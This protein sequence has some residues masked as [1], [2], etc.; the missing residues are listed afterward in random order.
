MFSLPSDFSSESLGIDE[1]KNE[2]KPKEDEE[3]EK[4]EEEDED[5]K[6]QEELEQELEEELKN[7]EEEEHNKKRSKDFEDEDEPQTKKIKFNL[8]E[9][10]DEEEEEE[11]EDSPRTKKRKA[12]EEDDRRR[13]KTQK[14]LSALT[15]TQNKRYEMYKRSKFSKSKMKSLISQFIPGVTLNES[16]TIVMCGISKL[17]VGDLVE[18]SKLIMRENNEQ[19][20]I[21]P[22]HI[23]EAYRKL[24]REGKIPHLQKKKFLM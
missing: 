10:E 8:P 15:P 18:Y 1:D 13:K 5:D 7:V 3:E 11:P 21:Q 16:M 20:P 19:G 4:Q 22:H 2:K 24:D 14:I 12:E 6:M 9:F 17:F 23:R